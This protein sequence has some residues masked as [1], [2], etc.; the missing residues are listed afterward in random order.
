MVFNVSILYVDNTE[1][2]FIHQV[3]RYLVHLRGDVS[4]EIRCDILLQAH[5]MKISSVSVVT[6]YLKSATFSKD[7]RCDF[8]LY[9]VH[10]T[11]TANCLLSIKLHITTVLTASVV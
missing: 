6:K 4:T 5:I 1:L 11:R 3:I 7:S 9:S 10:A 2:L 8:A